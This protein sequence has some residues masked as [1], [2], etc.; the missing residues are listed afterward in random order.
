ML[1]LQ[2][3]ADEMER[4]K[5]RQRTYDA[6]VRKARARHVTGGRVFGYYNV[7][8]DGHAKRVCCLYVGF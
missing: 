1:S 5:A 6:M 3:M 2:T 7:K 4:E 8:V